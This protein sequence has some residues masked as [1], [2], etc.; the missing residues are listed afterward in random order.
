MSSI[1]AA[2]SGW[3]LAGSL[4]LRD[5]DFLRVA[6]SKIVFKFGQRDYFFAGV[7]LADVGFVAFAIGI[8]FGF[9][10][11]F[12]G[13][14]DVAFGALGRRIAPAFATTTGEVANA[15]NSSC[16][17]RSMPANLSSLGTSSLAAI[18]P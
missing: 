10:L 9:I 5:C 7:A 14:L 12:A 4:G 3:S 16:A 17:A 6:M 13:T 15:S 1:S 2:H 11:D 8:V 18:K